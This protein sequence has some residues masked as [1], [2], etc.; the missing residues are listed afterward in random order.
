MG[1]GVG[2]RAYEVACEVAGWAGLVQERLSCKRFHRSPI[3]IRRLLCPCGQVFKFSL[4]T[5]LA[6][7]TSI[8]GFGSRIVGA[9]G[10]MLPI[11]D[12]CAFLSLVVVVA[13]RYKRKMD[14]H[15]KQCQFKTCNRFRSGLSLARREVRMLF[16]MVV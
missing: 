3:A 9:L 1:G 5:G 15:T 13:R 14:F 11:V 16:P 8:K 6:M 12:L 2:K 4:G 7:C 10:R